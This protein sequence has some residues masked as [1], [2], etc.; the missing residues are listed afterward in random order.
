M[1]RQIAC[2]TCQKRIAT[3]LDKYEFYRKELKLGRGDAADKAQLLKMCCRATAFSQTRIEERVRAAGR[4]ETVKNVR[5]VHEIQDYPIRTPQR[6]QNV[7]GEKVIELATKYDKVITFETFG[8]LEEGI[9]KIPLPKIVTFD[10][11]DDFLPKVTNIPHDRANLISSMFRYPNKAW[12]L[13]DLSTFPYPEHLD[14]VF[15][16]V[17][18]KISIQVSPLL[19]FRLPLIVEAGVSVREGLEQLRDVVMLQRQDVLDAVLQSSQMQRNPKVY[20]AALSDARD[21]V[22]MSAFEVVNG[23]TIVS[24]VTYSRDTKTYTFE[25]ERE[26]V[27]MTAKDGETQRRLLDATRHKRIE[28]VRKVKREE[29]S[30]RR[31]VQRREGEGERGRE[32]GETKNKDES[33]EKETLTIVKIGDAELEFD[34]YRV[35]SLGEVSQTIPL[36]GEIVGVRSTEKDIDYSDGV[37]VLVLESLFRLKV[38]AKQIRDKTLI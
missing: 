13:S 37:I 29:G 20:R 19:S 1:E 27:K 21:K 32:R 35:E 7:T 14:A 4:V 10:N 17:Q 31:G 36:G 26:V 15:N 2:F 5:V 8:A 18:V 38:G 34:A 16:A 25:I 30:E 33:E 28:E 23:L 22:G 12:L 3:H 9:T 6:R 11:V 24:K